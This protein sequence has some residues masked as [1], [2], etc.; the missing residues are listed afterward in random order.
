MLSNK[1][2]QILK[3]AQVILQADEEHKK[4]F[5]SIPLVSF[6]RAKTLQDT[7]VRAKLPSLESQGGSCQGCNR[8][9]CLVDAFLDT[10]ETFSNS[11]QSRTFQLREGAL[12]CNT[13]FVVYRLSCKTC[14]MQYIGSAKT[15]FRKRINNYKS[16]F[17]AYCNQKNVGTVHSKVVP[18]GSLFEHFLQDNHHG[19]SDLKFQ[20]IDRSYNEEQLRKRESFWQYK[21]E[22]FVP[23]GLNERTVPT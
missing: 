14:N 6:R 18:Q 17:R 15:P 16:Q 21:L 12:N 5:P 19:M 20:L 8:S 7:L 22:T 9:N 13:K 10:S 11:D 23:K 3:E 1:I 4:L 2:Y